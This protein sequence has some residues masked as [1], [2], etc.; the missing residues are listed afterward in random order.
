[1]KKSPV[2]HPFLFALFPILALY[3]FNITQVPTRQIFVPLG[4]VILLTLLLWATLNLIFKEKRKSGL[5]VFL[6]L[7][8][9][10]SYGHF[11]K[12]LT[13]TGLEIGRHRYL[14]PFWI[15][16]FVLM[17]YLIVK[18]KS[19][20]HNHTL[21]LNVITAFLVISPLIQIVPFQLK[22]WSAKEELVAA[23]NSISFDLEVPESTL[24]SPP[25][26]TPDIYY[27]IFD[28]YANSNVLKQ[29]F[30]Y[31]NSDFTNY[32]TERGFYL[33]TESQANYPRTLLSLASSLNMEYLD[34]LMVVKE[35]KDD[36]IMYE[37]VQ[38]YRVWRLLKARGYKFIHFGDWWD[39]TKINR[40]ADLN[41]NYIPL[42][43]NGFAEM[44]LDT[45]ILKPAIEIFIGDSK[46]RNR[47]KIRYKFQ[48]LADVPEIEGPKFV[49]VHTLLPHDPY[50]FGQ[51]G[52]PVTDEEL[53]ARSES[54]NYINQLIFTN[55]Q[56]KL[57]IDQILSKSAS[58]PIIIIQS[59]EGPF[60]APEVL[61]SDF[62]V[63]GD[64]NTV[65]PAVLKTH[66]KI[67]N[68][69]YLPNSDR[70]LLYQSISPVN[71]F[72]IIFDFYFGTNYELLEDQSFISAGRKPFD[73]IPAPDFSA[74]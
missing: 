73:L 57:L 30:G 4:T 1:M 64:W 32:L 31:D 38:D 44:L 2:L 46:V 5:L 28:R 24:G 45:T 53:A 66:M 16:L 42:G 67:L 14:V 22:R 13:A 17:T 62:M 3:A 43:T 20:L 15:L 56:I 39:P 10:F 40:F 34:Y 72:R 19:N 70:A 55:K 65:S 47:E 18:T 8:L 12:G 37:M 63:T 21:I 11:Q 25:V 49:F 6:I 61:A 74:D 26:E 41:F 7:F 33:A 71:S 48:E 58:P 68:A 27:F 59:D 51:N 52:E 69:Y 29:S 50:I 23:R 9:F 54:D 35:S 60:A 36:T